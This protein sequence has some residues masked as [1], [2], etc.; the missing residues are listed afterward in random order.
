[1]SIEVVSI[2]TLSKNGSVVRL[3]RRMEPELDECLFA[4]YVGKKER[5][6]YRLR[7]HAEAASADQAMAF[8]LAAIYN[9][10]GELNV[11]HENRTD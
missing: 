3:S 2:E 8:F 7:L 1:M 5:D 6:T 4:I 9:L 10:I 11:E